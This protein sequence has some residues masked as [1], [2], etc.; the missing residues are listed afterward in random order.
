MKIAVIGGG[1][2]GSSVALLLAKQGEDVTVFEKQAVPAP[3]GAGIMLQIT[4][5]K[6]LEEVGVR[7]QIADNGRKITRFTGVTKQERTVFDIDFSDT[8]LGAFGYGVHRS[9]LFESLQN[10]LNRKGVT[11]IP[12]KNIVSVD[13]KSNVK[14]SLKDIKGEVFEGFDFVIVANGSSSIIRNEIS[15]LRTSKKQTVSALWVTVPFEEKTEMQNQMYQVYDGTKGMLGVMPIGTGGYNAQHSEMNFFYGIVNEFLNDWSLDNFESW[16]LKMKTLCPKY[17]FIIDRID[18]FDSI[19]HAPYFDVEL[20]SVYS[21]K[22]LFMG[23]AAHATGPHLSSGTNLG[24]LDAVM[25][26][27]L[28]TT[29][30]K[31]L[32]SLFRTYE[33]KRKQQI[34]YYLLISRIITPMFQSDKNI[35]AFLRDN[36]LSLF[37]KLPITKGILLDTILGYRESVWSRLDKKYYILD[38]K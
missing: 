21:G 3:V 17:S 24:L 2:V 11:L 7:D 22:V 15:S 26:S 31:D 20:R 9:N 29:M 1:P 35:Y 13:Q 28:F 36:M 33:K 8:E 14:V 32:S 6:V 10:Q 38:K 34:S 23:D 5:L 30:S 16:K 19:V 18:S 4:G 27:E 37:Y 25:F 12:G